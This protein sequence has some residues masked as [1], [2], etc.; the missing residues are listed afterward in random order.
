VDDAQRERAMAAVTLLEG[1]RRDL[2][3]SLTQIPSLTFLAQ[4][5]LLGVLTRESVGWA[6]AV[7]IAVAGVIATFAQIFVL[8]VVRVR[9]IRLHKR[10]R[11]RANELGLGELDLFYG[12]MRWWKLGWGLWP[13]VMALFIVADVL[14]L[15]VT[16]R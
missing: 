1:R 9:V 13:I 15:V 12:R 3:T 4:A 11:S 2:Q 10:V 8:V 7:P 6:V 16:P 5:F 14:A